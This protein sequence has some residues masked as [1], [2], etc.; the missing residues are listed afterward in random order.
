MA[1]PPFVYTNPLV[2]V[3][4][5]QDYLH[6]TGLVSV[7]YH[8]PDLE[9]ARALAYA[10]CKEYGLQGMDRLIQHNQCKLTAPNKVTIRCYDPKM[11]FADGVWVNPLNQLEVRKWRLEQAQLTGKPPTEIYAG[12]V[13][14]SP[15]LGP[16]VGRSDVDAPMKIGN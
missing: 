2:T 11:R 16:P 15:D 4:K 5:D 9:Q 7:C 1:E 14:A 3:S 12:P 10:T 6:R 8:D 13:Q